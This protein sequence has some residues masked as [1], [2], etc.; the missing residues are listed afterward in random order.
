MF[1]CLAD[2]V[3]INQKS[4]NR[5][6]KLLAWML[7]FSILF[8]V[9]LLLVFLVFNLPKNLA[10]LQYFLLIIGLV[11]SFI[12][13]Y[14]LNCAGHYKNAAILF[15]LAASVTPWA[16]LLFDESILLG[17][18]VPLL[19]IT[20]PIILCS[21]LLSTGFTIALSFIQYTGVVLVLIHNPNTASF[22][23]ISFLVFIFLTTIF[24]I[25]QNTIT[26]RDI[27]KITDQN[28]KLE[29]QEIRLREQSVRDHLTNLFNRRY[30]EETLDR[31]IQRSLRNQSPLGIMII[32]IDEFKHINDTLGHSAGD[33]AIKNVGKF[34][35]EHIRTSDIACRYGGDEFVLV[36][37]DATR[38][39]LL[40]RAEVLR[41]GVKSL[42]LP[43]H[44]SIS[45]GLAVS[46]EHGSDGDT[47]LKLADA[48][49]YQAKR[50]GRNK[51][52]LAD[53]PVNQD[54]LQSTIGIAEPN[55]K[56]GG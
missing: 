2:A 21:I 18:F 3:M 32:D 29:M 54:Q 51:S 31:E 41:N 34:I 23:W 52:I 43:V 48:A 10:K 30:L 13:A 5:Q 39:I 44:F 26:Q 27:K 35:V 12:I 50:E 55:S 16:S 17:D 9:T 19:Y 42:G 45:L 28:E 8:S 22:N 40:E 38:E 1:K 36:L 15:V 7:V 53:L 24:N 6:A 46:P 11:I 47:L 49:L 33:T 56:P 4:A 25:L 37:P 20:L 14:I